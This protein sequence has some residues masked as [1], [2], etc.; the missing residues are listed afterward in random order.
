[1][2]VA[3]VNRVDP[4]CYSGGSYVATP[5]GEILEAFGSKHEEVV[6]RDIDLGQI[7]RAKQSRYQ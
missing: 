1:M 7:S 3:T 5:L 4:G 2:F 6:L